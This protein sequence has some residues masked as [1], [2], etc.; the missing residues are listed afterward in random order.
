MVYWKKEKKKKNFLVK[1]II[2]LCPV[3]VFIMKKVLCDDEA[4][5]L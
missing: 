5:L 2:A 4:V 3:R 1:N